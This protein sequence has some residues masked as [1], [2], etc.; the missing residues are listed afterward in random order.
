[1]YLDVLGLFSAA[2]L[3]QPTIEWTHCKK[4]KGKGWMYMRWSVSIFL[5]LSRFL[6]P[7]LI[8]TSLILYPRHPSLCRF[9]LPVW[10]LPFRLSIPH[11]SAPVPPTV[12]L[13]PLTLFFPHVSTRPSFSSP[14][15]SIPPGSS[16]CKTKHKSNLRQVS[17]SA[18]VF[19][20]DLHTQNDYQ[21]GRHSL[22]AC[23]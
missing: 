17:I 9:P 6:Y 12:Q 3:P 2:V 5:G 16:I 20:S 11:P 18:V 7:F 23:K 19:T 21:A 22:S 10:N 8:E 4:K 1:M 15:C 13:Y 14:S